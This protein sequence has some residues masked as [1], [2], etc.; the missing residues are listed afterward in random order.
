M[1]FIIDIRRGNLDLQ[2]MYKALFELSTDRADFLSR[3]FAKKRPVGL[4]PTSTADEIFTAIRDADKSDEL[5]TQ[6]LKAIQ[7]HLAI[8]HGFELTPDDVRGV[9]YVYH[10]FFMFG[11]LIQYSSTGN[12]GGAFQPSYMELMT[13]TDGNGKSQGFLANEENFQFM[14]ELETKNL[15]VPVVGN[16]GGLK[17]IRAVAQYVKEL[18]A[19]VSAFYLS[20]VEQYLRIDGLWGQFCENVASLPLDAKS[21]FIRSVRRTNDIA[22]LGLSSELGA[23]QSEVQTCR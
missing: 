13:A 16:F 4:S 15:L 17:A 1:V 3:L 23:M 14:K 12:S 22:T 9:E 6:N 2:L 8:T 10:A 11:P 5:F 21:T 20:N 18:G 19:T 7:D